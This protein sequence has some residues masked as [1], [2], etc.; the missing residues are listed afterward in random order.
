MATVQNVE[1]T[2]Y[3]ASEIVYAVPTIKSTDKLIWTDHEGLIVKRSDAYGGSDEIIIEE[4]VGCTVK[5]TGIDTA[6]LDTGGTDYGLVIFN[7]NYTLLFSGDVT[8]IE[9]AAPE[10]EEAIVTTSKYTT[11]RKIAND[12][13]IADC[14]DACNFYIPL[15]ANTNIELRNMADGDYVTVEVEN[16]GANA[17][18]VSFFHTALTLKWQGQA[19]PEQTAGQVDVYGFWRRGTRIYANVL[20]NFDN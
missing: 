1:V 3:Q 18:T 4:G 16:T 15:L 11:P 8:V 14:S 9:G 2:Q 19:Q 13:P 20:D 10:E 17:F 5:L 12:L 7:P 6:K